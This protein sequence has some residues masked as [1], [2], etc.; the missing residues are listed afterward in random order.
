MILNNIHFHTQ[1][2]WKFNGGKVA[3][4]LDDAVDK[5]YK[6]DNFYIGIPCKDCDKK[7]YDYYNNRFSKNKSRVTYGNLF[8]NK[9]WDT[10]I[11]FIKQHKIPFYYIGPGKHANIE[12]NVIDRFFIDEFL[13]ESWD[14]QRDIILR[15]LINWVK[16]KPTNSLFFFSAGPLTKIFVPL[17]L[18]TESNNSYIDCGSALDL[19]LKGSTN[20]PYILDKNSIYAKMICDFDRGHQ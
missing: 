17:L 13:I 15:N 3:K 16:S 12:L 4:D 1:D 11:N 14:Q 18:E 9:N 20:R 7:M 19:F 2:I 5:Y 10:F 8:Q 6:L